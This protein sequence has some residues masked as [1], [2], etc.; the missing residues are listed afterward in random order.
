MLF[1]VCGTRFHGDISPY[2]TLTTACLKQT[3]LSRDYLTNQRLNLLMSRKS[4][5]IAW[6][7]PERSRGRDLTTVSDILLGQV[8]SNGN[9]QW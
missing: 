8:S 1:P 3:T 6:Y 9:L 7:Q 5:Q 4:R 2:V